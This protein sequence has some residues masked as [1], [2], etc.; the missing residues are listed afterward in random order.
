M[1]QIIKQLTAYKIKLKNG[2]NA[3]IEILQFNH[4]EKLNV[5][6]NF[7]NALIKATN[8]EIRNSKKLTQGSRLYN[9]KALEVY[10]KWM[11]ILNGICL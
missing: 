6:M 3:Y 2:A 5:T 8:K 7:V 10:L 1:I 11:I 9:Y 4:S